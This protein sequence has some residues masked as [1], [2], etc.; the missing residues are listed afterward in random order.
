MSNRI[1]RFFKIIAICVGAALLISSNFV[2]AAPSEEEM[3]LYNMLNEYR[4]ANG[5]PA[6]PLSPS[7]THVAQLHVRDLSR[8]PPSGKLQY[9]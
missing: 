5:L 9:A 1:I 3:R 2:Q 4:T 6:I 8:Y 7:L